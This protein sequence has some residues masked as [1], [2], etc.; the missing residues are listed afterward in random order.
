MACEIIKIVSND[1]STFDVPINVIK[2]STTLRNMFDD[3]ADFIN[4]SE[5]QLPNVSSVI[6]QKVLDYCNRF[7]N[8]PREPLDVKK[9][10]LL[11][12]EV[13][14]CNMAQDELFDVIVAA[15]YLDIRPLLDATSYTVAYMIKGKTPDEIRK[16]FNIENDLSPEEE[17]QLKKE[18]VWDDE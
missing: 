18:N 1:N 11:D 14:F 15:N 16:T 2:L 7:V 10:V 13:E 17:E 8:R 12:W 9:P 4:E 6:L 5:L 3:V